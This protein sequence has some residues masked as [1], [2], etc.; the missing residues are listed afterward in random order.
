MSKKNLKINISNLVKLG[1]GAFGI[2]IL[3]ECNTHHIANIDILSQAYS[4]DNNLY[5]DSKNCNPENKYVIKLCKNFKK[6]KDFKNEEKLG[7]LLANNN[8]VKING[9]HKN[10]LY[11]IEK[12]NLNDNVKDKLENVINKSLGK[13]SNKALLLPFYNGNSLADY[14]DTDKKDYSNVYGNSLSKSLSNNKFIDD[15]FHGINFLHKMGWGHFDIKPDNIMLHFQSETECKAVLIDYGFAKQIRDDKGDEL[16]LLVGCGTKPYMSPEIWNSIGCNY[17]PDIWA[18]GVTIL[19]ICTKKLTAFNYFYLNKKFN[20]PSFEIVKR[21][22]N[23]LYSDSDLSSRGIN[24]FKEYYIKIFKLLGIDYVTIIKKI[25]TIQ[26]F[27]EI[28]FCLDETKRKQRFK[29]IA[30]LNRNVNNSN[31]SRI[32]K[33]ITLAGVKDKIKKKIKTKK[34]FLKNNKK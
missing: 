28:F 9:L 18:L 12:I 33:K 23:K 17:G 3:S 21:F 31:T 14:I 11:V 7:K 34:I 6:C 10:L 8:S 20:S 32:L 13:F 29:N 27:L 24:L 15:I 4:L 25:Y 19:E 26:E 5:I 16:E 22:A 2:N 1:E 30:Y